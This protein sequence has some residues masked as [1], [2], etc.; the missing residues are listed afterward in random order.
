VHQLL[1][2]VVP[3]F[4]TLFVSIF[5]LMSQQCIPAAVMHNVVIGVSVGHCSGQHGPGPECNASL[6]SRLYPKGRVNMP[7]TGGD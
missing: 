2:C 7:D 3:G 4:D 6:G 5:L 1:F